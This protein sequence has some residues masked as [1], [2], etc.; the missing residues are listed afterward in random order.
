MCA[1]AGEREGAEAAL[2][3]AAFEYAISDPL[4]PR[5]LDSRRQF[6]PS[7]RRQGGGFARR[8]TEERAIRL[9]RR[10]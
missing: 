10:G 3:A 7:H 9:P 1:N 2:F 8:E 4:G 5:L 6:G